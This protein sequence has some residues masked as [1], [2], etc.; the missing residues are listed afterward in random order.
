MVPARVIAPVYSIIRLIVGAIQ[1][2][3][4][5]CAELQLGEGR[6]HAACSHRPSFDLQSTRFCSDLGLGGRQGAASTALPCEPFLTTRRTSP[7]ST[8]RL[9]SLLRLSGRQVCQILG[10]NGFIEVRRRGS[11][12]A[13]SSFDYRGQVLD[14]LHRPILTPNRSSSVQGGRR[15]VPRQR[16]DVPV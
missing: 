13:S 4:R 1:L 15:S 7:I 11:H 12:I 10:D 5:S 16:P 3:H 6:R 2:H 9:G 8:S 14:A